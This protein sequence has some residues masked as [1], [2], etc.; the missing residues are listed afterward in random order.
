MR[1]HAELPDA[2]DGRAN[3]RELYEGALPVRYRVAGRDEQ[4]PL[5]VKV[6]VALRYGYGEE[7][8][9]KVAVTD[10]ENPLLLYA[11]E[12]DGD[13]Y[14]QLKRKL[15]LLIDF[16]QFPQQLVGLLK[17]C[18]P[19]EDAGQ[20]AASKLALLLEESAADPYDV[21]EGRCVL[22]KIVE[23]NDFQRLCLVALHMACGTEAEVN[24]FMA[25]NVRLLKRQARQ[26][27]ERL[28]EAERRW[29][30][31]EEAANAQRAEAERV[32]AEAGERLAE[33]RRAHEEELT[34]AR[35]DVERAR[36]EYERRLR[37]AAG[38]A[39]ERVRAAAAKREATVERLHEELAATKTAHARLEL[40]LAHKGETQAKMV[41]DLK[42][43]QD[44]LLR[45]EG[46]VARLEDEA[47][48]RGA[49]VAGA[50]QRVAQLE[51]EKED[52]GRAMKKLG[53]LLEAADASKAR[54]KTLLK[55]KLE[56]A[57][58]QMAGL[59]A[60]AKEL[61]KANEI[62]AKLTKENKQLGAK[63]SERTKIA[64][65][66]ERV[67]KGCQEEL[68]HSR[69]IVEER[70][71]QI[72]LLESGTEELKGRLSSCEESCQQKDKQ[73]QKNEQVIGWL[74][75]VVSQQ[76]TSPPASRGSNTTASHS[77]AVDGG[78]LDKK[79]LQLTLN[80]SGNAKTN[81]TVARKANRS[82][83]MRGK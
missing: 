4:L 54:L 55:E 42:M 79:L 18:G 47:K 45:S 17:Q 9:L 83:S 67:I 71:A 27:E 13:A 14:A 49:L 10:A 35:R 52:K 57:D 75:D 24:A 34:E 56:L 5:T 63:L 8:L 50:K 32:R 53:A 82:H 15:G 69:Q 38:A 58:S 68:A 16:A 22:L 7:K 72:R 73:I 29:A 81:A 74:R 6:S 39:D 40:E 65:A 36:A 59:A 61:A 3:L 43:L 70:S 80:G 41:A 44:E 26:L 30:A 76:G 19:A 48:E 51:R 1:R 2:D 66:Q 20:C 21:V 31:A 60:S 23:A 12:V 11:T 78:T 33:M 37:E 28:A 77:T 25:R 46:R 62:I 64:V